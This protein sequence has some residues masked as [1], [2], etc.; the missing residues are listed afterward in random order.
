MRLG[1]GKRIPLSK[2]VLS[3]AQARTRDID[4]GMDELVANMRKHGQLAAIVVSPVESSDKFEIVTGQRRYLAAKRLG[5]RDLM[6]VVCTKPLD[7]TDARILSLSENVIRSEL[8]LRDTIDACTHL[9]RKYGS[10]ESVADELGLTP[11]KVASFVK[12]ERLRP[13]LKEVV[14]TGDADVVLALEIEDLMA[15]IEEEHD[16]LEP[17]ALAKNLSHLSKVQRR[18]LLKKRDI[19]ELRNLSRS[20][21]HPLEDSSLPKQIVVTIECDIHSQLREYAKERGIT[22]DE[23][24]ADLIRRGLTP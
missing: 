17:V 21:A 22:Q 8:T 6:A 9:Y 18:A 19:E 23:A 15:N 13:E 7:E 24:A 11:L 12:Y 1:P 14:D 10:I 16:G 20:D 3:S 2:L 4:R 5:W